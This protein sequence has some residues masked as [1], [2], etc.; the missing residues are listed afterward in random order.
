[1]VF[2]ALQNGQSGQVDAFPDAG[3]AGG[4]GRGLLVSEIGA[5]VLCVVAIGAAASTGFFHAKAHGFYLLRLHA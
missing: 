1:M 4:A 3:Q 5:A 2:R